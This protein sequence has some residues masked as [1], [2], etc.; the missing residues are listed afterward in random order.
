MADS[1]LG[2]LVASLAALGRSI[3]E[4]FDP[5]RF[6]AEFSVPVQALLPHDRLLVA[7]LEEGGDSFTVFAEHAVRGPLLHEGRYTVD[8]DPGGRYDVDDF[9]LASVFAGAP[10]LIGGGEE[11]TPPR[12]PPH[13]SPRDPLRVGI[14]ARVGVPLYS[15]SRVIGAFAAASFAADVYTDAHVENCRR[16][17]DLIGPFIENIVLLQRER[18]RRQRLAALTHLTGVFGTSLKITE[19]LPRLAEAVRPVLDFDV[20]GAGLIEPPDRTLQLLAAVDDDRPVDLEPVALDELS[21]AARVERG[22]I[23]AIR[24]ATLEL[25]PHRMGDRRILDRGGRSALVA[26][27]VFGDQVRGVVYFGK[28]RPRWY[29]A[30]DVEV[31]R[32]LAAEIVLAVQHQRLADEQQRLAVVEARARR[33]EQHVETLRGA[34][35]ERYGFDRIVGRAPEF[36]ALLDQARKVAATETTVL[37]T[38]E[39]GTG[40]EVLARAIHHE[41][42]RA[43]GPF[44]A[45]NCAAL[46]DTLIESELFGHERGAFTGADKLKRGRFELAAGGTLFLDEIG[47]LAPAMQAKLLRVLQ[48]REF[49]RVG[50]TATLRADV[51]LITATNRDLEDAVA[52]GRFRDDLF[53]R[54]AVF[55]L[56]LPALRERGDDVL[57]LAAHF[58]RALGAKM[59]RGEPGLSRDARDLLLAHHWPGNIRELQN[60]VERALIISDGALLTADHL[61]ITTRAER[62]AAAAPAAGPAAAAEAPAEAGSLAELEKRS[63]VAA[64]QRAKGNKSRAAGALG[65]TRTQLYTRLK[66]FG[67]DD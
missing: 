20:M 16:I 58:V 21:F 33:L 25:D 29:D 6:L 50:G 15:G 22:E 65:I 36:R 45:I 48:E 5:Q 62:P 4:R 40:K 13:Q 42:Q 52:H 56:R 9:G 63:I 7:Y 17:A 43:D 39:S 18:R 37:L 64:L 30:A 44:V 59:G 47:D 57:A 12:V 35:D 26:P 41:S 32:A 53:Y 19:V 60:A 8:F 55:R 2:D 28:R 51:R 1:R 31:A 27:L 46:P 24:D 10:L 34:L 11:S 23:V 54:L 66:R 3:Q 61:G 38:G 67:L 14:R 49:E